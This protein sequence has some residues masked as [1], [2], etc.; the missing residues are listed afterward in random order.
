MKQTTLAV[1]TAYP[2]VNE[3]GG[4]ITRDSAREHSL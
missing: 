4:D 3:N 1:Q 2:K